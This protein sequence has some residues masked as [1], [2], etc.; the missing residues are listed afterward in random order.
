MIWFLIRFYERLGSSYF[1]LRLHCC[2]DLFACL[3]G[4]IFVFPVLFALS[5][6]LI[7]IRFRLPSDIVRMY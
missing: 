3:C 1:W 4:S 2:L 6:F 7:L 5:V